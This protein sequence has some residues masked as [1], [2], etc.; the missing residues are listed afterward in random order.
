MQIK[1][2]Q[3]SIAPGLLPLRE[4]MILVFIMR[5][6]ACTARSGTGTGTG[7][8]GGA[9]GRHGYCVGSEKMRC[10]M[11][12]KVATRTVASL[13][14]GL[15]IYIYIDINVLEIAESEPRTDDGW[16]V[17]PPGKSGSLLPVVR[18]VLECY[19]GNQDH[20]V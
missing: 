17:V 9:C 5:G 20:V 15:Y 8:T 16:T 13:P 2:R 19:L 1:E 14:V 10:A 6:S 18:R 4:W 3:P 11:N 12:S 7:G